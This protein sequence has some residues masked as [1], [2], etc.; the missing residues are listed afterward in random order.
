MS[1]KIYDVHIRQFQIPIC[2]GCIELKGESCDTPGCTFIRMDTAEIA[3]M[4]DRL[5]IRPVIDGKR[6]DE[7]L[8]EVRR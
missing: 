5:L 8:N 3:E 6:L 2:N 7:V 4:L 1:Y